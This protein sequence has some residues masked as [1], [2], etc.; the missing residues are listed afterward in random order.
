MPGSWFLVLGLPDG[1]LVVDNTSKILLSKVSLRWLNANLRLMVDG[2]SRPCHCLDITV[3]L[4]VVECVLRL[5]VG[6]VRVHLQ[7]IGLFIHWLFMSFRLWFNC[8][9]I[10]NLSV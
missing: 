2:M 6:K 7:Q 3:G 5:L 10:I 4:V 1:L 8:E 9:L